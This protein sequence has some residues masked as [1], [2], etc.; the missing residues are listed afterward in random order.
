MLKNIP[1]I[2]CVGFLIFFMW[3]HV[4]LL[5]NDPCGL[6]PSALSVDQIKECLK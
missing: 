6:P 2:I 4:W 1:F 3:M 5:V